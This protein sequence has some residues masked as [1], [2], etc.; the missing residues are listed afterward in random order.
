VIEEV[1]GRRAVVDCAVNL[2][3]EKRGGGIGGG[4]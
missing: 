1:E 2:A 4:G 3:G